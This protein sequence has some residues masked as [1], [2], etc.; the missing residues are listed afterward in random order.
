MKVARNPRTT[1]HLLV[2]AA[3]LG[4]SGCSSGGHRNLVEAILVTAA[5]TLA[6]GETRF[7]LELRDVREDFL[8]SD[9]DNFLA[10]SRAAKLS[11]AV[12]SQVRERCEALRRTR[13]QARH[14]MSDGLAIIRPDS[15]RAYAD[16]NMVVYVAG[17]KD[18]RVLFSS[19]EIGQLL[20]SHEVGD[21]LAT[22][23]Y[24]HPAFD[25]PRLQALRDRVTALNLK[26]EGLSLSPSE[27]ER[28][29]I[30]AA[31][32][33]L[34]RWL[35][36]NG[37]R[38][39]EDAPLLVSGPLSATRSPRLT[40]ALQDPT[41]FEQFLRSNCSDAIRALFFLVNRDVVDLAYP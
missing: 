3:G 32:R 23:R 39:P 34:E 27:F 18:V 29:K 16:G 13:T 22:L 40:R 6:E 33:V 4:L 15:E 41:T 20:A 9:A 25:P 35:R 26:V 21:D 8:L 38:L 19:A 10:S 28:L 31:T 1:A 36:E 12:R 14:Q 2:A 5:P 24:T 11:H 30:E 7:V 17:K 37:Q